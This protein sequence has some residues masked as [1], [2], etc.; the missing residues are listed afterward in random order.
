MVGKDSGSG[1]DESGS[2]WPL[3]VDGV[4]LSLHNIGSRVIRFVTGSW[5]IWM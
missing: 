2:V 5:F 4:K 1:V 3:T